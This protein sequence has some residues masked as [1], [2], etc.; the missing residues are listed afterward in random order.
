MVL[1]LVVGGLYSAT[2]GLP[3][4]IGGGSGG[5]GSATLPHAS[6][7]R[8]PD[9]ASGALAAGPSG[10]SSV[11]LQQG[12]SI[13]QEDENF[14]EQFASLSASFTLP[15]GPGS[16]GYSLNGVTQTGDWAQAIVADNWPLPPPPCG[17]PP[18]FVFL[19]GVWA[20]NGTLVS[21]GYVC[22][23]NQTAP[24]SGDSIS[25]TLA[26]DCAAGGSNS[27]CFTFA[28]LTQ[29]TSFTVNA[30]QPTS[31]A[32]T[33]QNLASG[34][35]SDGN[36]FFTGPMTE[37]V[38]GPMATSCQS[39]PAPAAASYY[40]SGSDSAQNPISISQVTLWAE[41]SASSGTCFSGN[42]GAVDVASV[43]V[44][45]FDSVPAASFGGPFVQAGQNWTATGGTPA[46]WRFET[47]VNALAFSVSLSRQT[48]DPGQ[49]VQVTGSASGG[50]HP[51]SYRWMVN[52]TPSAATTASWSFTPSGSGT[53]NISG[54]AVDAQS[55][56]ALGWANLTVGASLSVGAPTA[57]PPSV[58]VGAMVT[59]QSGPVTGGDAPFTYT[60]NS[61]PSSCPSQ[62]SSS[63][64]C[65]PHTSGTYSISVT[66][67]D[68]LG[69]SNTSPVL[70]FTVQGVINVGASAS[71]SSIDVGQ[72]V[73]FSSSASGGAGGY[74]FDWTGLP[75]SCPTPAVT[76]DVNCT[77]VTNSGTFTVTVTIMDSNFGQGQ[78]RFQF[79]VYTDPFA[80]TPVVSKS[81]LDANTVVTVE[82]TVGGGTQSYRYAWG[83]L[84]PGSGCTSVTNL[85]HC[86]ATV[87]GSYS[88]WL[89]IT[90]SNGLSANS[91]AV[92]ILVHPALI[93]ATP[94]DL[95]GALDIGQYANFS[96]LVSG[97]APPYT[98]TWEGLPKCTV[99]QNQTTISCL[100]GNAT[101]TIYVVASDAT[102]NSVRGHSLLFQAGPPPVIQSFTV[103][104][105]SG[106]YPTNFTFTANVTGGTPPLKY[107]YSSLPPG[108][109]APNGPSFHCT[110]PGG[111]WTVWLNVTDKVGYEVNA[112]VHLTVST[113]NVPGPP[114][115]SFSVSPT[116]VAVGGTVT[117]SV[118][119]GNLTQANIQISSLRFDY[120]NLPTGCGSINS[121]T[122][123]CNPSIPG[124][125]NVTVY[126]I[127]SATGV[128][129][130]RTA[131]LIV[132]DTLPTGS[133]T[134][135][136]TFFGLP[137]AWA[138][139]VL[140]IVF[141]AIVALILL[142]RYQREQR[143]R[144]RPVSPYEYP[145]GAGE[146]AGG[147]AAGPTAEAPVEA[148][149]DV[150]ETRPPMP[151]PPSS[152]V[153]EP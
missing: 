116:S 99:G 86:N 120:Q 149:P 148:P 56:D 91:T 20:S 153:Y 42:S 73:T 64:T 19:Y 146:V 5:T 67:Q 107:S 98:V 66:V 126:V 17:G 68:V 79:R 151:E 31:G 100:I 128:T 97:G 135:P 27:I 35:T 36:G 102:G 89:T 30:T 49:P 118:Q 101:A 45:V 72:N 88:V 147:A 16:I 12:A 29:G 84:P 87:A 33:F 143:A 21:P 37:E 60:W 2:M 25:L 144:Q 58:D 93:V 32:S 40:I 41:E 3:G 109:S 77:D 92:P 65:R 125:Y 46:T 59:F 8:S 94:R 13:S 39:F 11:Y 6:S 81:A 4:P 131:S 114:I 1:L 70:S 106:K 111:N 23:T 112:S 18:G 129:S 133:S 78:G 61:L 138:A 124:T 54:Y 44:T 132:G 50:S 90:D 83:G 55:N 113:P 141:L 7:A 152:D 26:L 117:F 75:G 115:A 53:Y 142:Y 127:D 51:Y 15:G 122:L 34:A 9:L 150:P 14:G 105:T 63:I 48:S 28:D 110:P 85:V 103:D 121:S 69:S 123:T 57:T 62:N 108:C 119:L 22:P 136:R 43:P 139:L 95:S 130:K 145:T 24:A 96:V 52:G 104:P 82:V 140:A 80:Q 134:P 10:V 76:Q 38:A 74:T 137:L 71:P 47:N